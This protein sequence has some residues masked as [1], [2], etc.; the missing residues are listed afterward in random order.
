M[1]KQIALVFVDESPEYCENFDL[2]SIVTPIDYKIFR[3]LLI[4]TRYDPDEIDFITKGFRDG[5]DIGYDGPKLRQSRA[6]NLPFTIGSK[7]ILWNKLIK[8]VKNKRV[9]RP[10]DQT[11]FDYYIQSPIG[12]VPKAGGEQT[13]LIFH[14]SYD[15]SPEEK[16]VN[17]NTPKEI[18]SVKYTDSRLGINSSKEGD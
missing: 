1:A 14:L 16:Y 10:Y 6:R 17:A 13:K 11:P 4:D 8:E 7:T 3:Q 12:L 15:F 5:F 9:A 18:C 2:D